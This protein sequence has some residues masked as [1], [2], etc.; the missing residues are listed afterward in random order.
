[1]SWGVGDGDKV[2]IASSQPTQWWGPWPAA[3]YRHMLSGISTAGKPM[4]APLPNSAVTAGGRPAQDHGCVMGVGGGSMVPSMVSGGSM[5][6]SGRR[7]VWEEMRGWAA[8]R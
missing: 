3:L 2:T 8:R 4:A 6:P 5:V 7:P 1:M